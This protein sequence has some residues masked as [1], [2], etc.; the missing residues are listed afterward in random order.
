MKGIKCVICEKELK[1]GDKYFPINKKKICEKC[2][3]IIN[4]LCVC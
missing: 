3:K 4:P 2:Y 1:I